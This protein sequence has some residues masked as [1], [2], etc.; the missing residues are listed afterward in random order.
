MT[1]GHSE[2]YFADVLLGTFLLCIDSIEITRK[3]LACVSALVLKVE[4][5]AAQRKLRIVM[6]RLL[7]FTKGKIMN[8]YKILG[9]Q[10]QT[11]RKSPTQK[12]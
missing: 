11:K 4:L 1:R 3:L 6:R 8:T 10:A 9:G 2:F 7:A 12:N 5:I